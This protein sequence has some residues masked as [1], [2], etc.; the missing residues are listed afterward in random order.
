MPI[1]IEC[2]IIKSGLQLPVK[3]TSQVGELEG[4]GPSPSARAAEAGVG[5]VG[6]SWLRERGAPGTQ[7]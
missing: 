1:I 3:E 2:Y 7:L 6:S 5:M 4:R